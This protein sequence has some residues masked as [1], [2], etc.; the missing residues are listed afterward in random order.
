MSS[1]SLRANVASRWGWLALAVALF[2]TSLPAFAA[3]GP[4]A[5][6]VELVPWSKKVG[7]DRYRSSRDFKKTRKHFRETLR[8]KP[9]KWHRIV[10]LP[11]VK[12]FHI[13]NLKRK[14]RWDG[15]NVYE[16]PNGRV[17]MYVLKHNPDADK[18]KKPAKK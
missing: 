14:R 18:A 4:K 7:K 15:V 5:H 16:L 10:N 1:I 13:E 2:A 3:D 9:V 12:Y 6:G 17:M 11:S 8:G